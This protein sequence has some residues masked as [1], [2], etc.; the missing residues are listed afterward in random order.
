[1]LS[2]PIGA[3]FVLGLQWFRL[4]GFLKVVNEQLATFIEA[5]K[6][7]LFDIRFFCV[8]LAILVFTFGDMFH[9]I[10]VHDDDLD[11]T[12]SQDDFSASQ[13]FCSPNVIDSYLRVYAVIIGDAQLS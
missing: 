3:A 10:F 7:I 13:D 2:S 9:L 8:V 4:L 6:Q 12:E 5:L 1:M 11:C